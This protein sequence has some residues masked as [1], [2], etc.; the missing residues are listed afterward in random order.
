[1]SREGA[2]IQ[3]VSGK[4]D[5]LYAYI[6]RGERELTAPS[7]YMTMH[8]Q[9]QVG[10]SAANTVLAWFLKK[11]LHHQKSR[12]HS[13]GSE[14]LCKVAVRQPAALCAVQ[15]CCCRGL[16]SAWNRMVSRE[17]SGGWALQCTAVLVAL[18]CTPT[19]FHSCSAS[20]NPSISRSLSPILV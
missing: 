12:M 5:V 6:I 3:L 10:C 8:R 19:L 17:H 16:F 9:A 7:L 4:V 1:M 14:A 18:L 15:L 2:M 11:S 20:D 13:S